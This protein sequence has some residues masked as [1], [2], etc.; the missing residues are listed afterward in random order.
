MRLI[1]A[2]CW[3][4]FWPKKATSGSTALNSFATTVVTPAKVRGAAAFGVATE[5]FG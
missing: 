5:H 3:A 4:S 1:T 2:T